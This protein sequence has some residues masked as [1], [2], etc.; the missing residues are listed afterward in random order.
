MSSYR[1]HYEG[2]SEI[3]HLISSFQQDEESILCAYTLWEGLDV[4]G[5]SLSAVI[6]WDLPWPPLDPVFNA[7]RKE[8]SDAFAEVEVPFMQR[9][10]QGI[11]RLIRTRDDRGQVVIMGER[12]RDEPSRQAVLDVLPAGTLQEENS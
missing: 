7:R 10:R 4:P 6:I 1:I 2:S 3:S 11:G 5:P 9:M 8:S 12:L